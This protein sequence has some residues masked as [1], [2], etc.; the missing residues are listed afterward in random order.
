MPYRGAW[1]SVAALVGLTFC[2]F[3]PG[4]FSDFVGNSAYNHFY[5]ATGFAWMALLSA[6]SWL[7]DHKKWAL[8]RWQGRA[9]LAV[10][11]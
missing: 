7:V 2:V 6:Q 1:R 5:A 3:W 8:H 4:Y 10:I 11:P 9:M